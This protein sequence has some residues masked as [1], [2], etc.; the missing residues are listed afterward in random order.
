V[1]VHPAARQRYQGAV[2]TTPERGAMRDRVGIFGRVV[3]LG[4]IGI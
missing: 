2:G 4:W 1:R 3:K